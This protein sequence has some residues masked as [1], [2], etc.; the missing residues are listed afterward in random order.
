[1]PKSPKRTRIAA[2][3]AAAPTTL[4]FIAVFYCY[5]INFQFNIV[6]SRELPF[7][8]VPSTEQSLSIVLARNSIN[9][10]PAVIYRFIAHSACVR[11]L[12]RNFIT[13]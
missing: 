1:M 8:T 4:L 5:L 10:T 3:A 6:I 7:N 12:V 9:H 13:F 11:D 2:A